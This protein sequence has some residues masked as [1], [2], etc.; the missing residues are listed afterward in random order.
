M[1]MYF[2]D[3]ACLYHEGI[4]RSRFCTLFETRKWAYIISDRCCQH[5]EIDLIPG[6]HVP[7]HTVVSPPIPVRFIKNIA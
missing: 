4:D 3:N 7:P 6:Q 1:Q 5:F 2:S